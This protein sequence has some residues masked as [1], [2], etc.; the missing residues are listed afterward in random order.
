MRGTAFRGRKKADAKPAAAKATGAAK[1][2][3]AAKPKTKAAP[4]AKGKKK[5]QSSDD[6]DGDDDGK[7]E[8]E[9][10]G[11]DARRAG[12]GGWVH[13]GAS[14]AGRGGGAPEMGSISEGEH[15]PRGA[16]ATRARVV[17]ARG[18]MCRGGPWPGMGRSPSPR[19]LYSSR[20]R[21]A[22]LSGRVLLPNL[23]A[24]RAA[25]VVGVRMPRVH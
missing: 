8:G 17:G 21:L 19:L 23:S 14:G 18:S 16:R 25:Q 7:E 9:G 4:S 24:V 1:A 15:G 11:E 2:K 12:G 6:D 3:A 5:A 13:A 20:D 10:A 22:M